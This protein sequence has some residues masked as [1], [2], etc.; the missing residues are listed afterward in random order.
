[1]IALDA[2]ETGDQ[3]GGY[4]LLVTCAVCGGPCA[5]RNDGRPRPSHVSAIF[6]CVN[7][8]CAHEW[9][10]HA[11]L[12][13][14]SGAET[15]QGFPKHHRVASTR[16]QKGWAGLSEEQRAERMAKVRAAKASRA[17]EHVS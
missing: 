8:M 3:I 7:P 9:V 12:L 13:Q 15:G 11:Q 4:L 17:A 1:M 16:A 10:L 2:V 5:H 6:A 14:A